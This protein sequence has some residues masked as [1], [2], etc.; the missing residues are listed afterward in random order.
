MVHQENSH[1]RNHHILVDLQQQRF[2]SE[3]LGLK[4]VEVAADGARQASPA[5]ELAAIAA[6]TFFAAGG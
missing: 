6:H 3:G 4:V 5:R 2:W 1:S